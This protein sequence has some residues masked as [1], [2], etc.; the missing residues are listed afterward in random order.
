MPRTRSALAAISSPR[1]LCWV[2]VVRTR[3]RSDS[4]EVTTT[5][6]EKT[7][8]YEYMVRVGDSGLWAFRDLLAQHPDQLSE[9]ASLDAHAEVDALVASL[10]HEYGSSD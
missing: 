5:H 10:L 3:T 7:D 2:D 4:T 9:S 6:V 8:G 1:G